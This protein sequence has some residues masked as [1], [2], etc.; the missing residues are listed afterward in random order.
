MAV[1]EFDQFVEYVTEGEGGE[2]LVH[3]V[4]PHQLSL[5]TP[6]V[7]QALQEG[8]AHA[9]SLG[10]TLTLGPEG[11]AELKS[12]ALEVYH[13]D[14]VDHEVVGGNPAQIVDRLIEVWSYPEVHLGAAVIA[15][16]TWFFEGNLHTA[17]LTHAIHDPAWLPGRPGAAA[18]WKRFYEDAAPPWEQPLGAHDAYK[19]GAK[20]THKGFVWES[21]INANVWEPGAPGTEALW[22]QVGPV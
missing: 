18:L 10:R 15:G 3:F 16:E 21:A 7:L 9:A 11:V 8:Y 20:V 14:V 6:L 22:Q 12:A 13:Q 17:I 19:K 1:P 5:D 4:L 2:P